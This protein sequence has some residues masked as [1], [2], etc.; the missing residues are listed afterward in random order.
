M[1]ECDASPC[2]ANAA[3]SNTE[4]GYNCVCNDNFSGDGFSC[5]LDDLCASDPCDANANCAYDAA[6]VTCT[7]QDGY[8]GSKIFNY[9]I[10]DPV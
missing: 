7:C 4:G 10:S 8:Q 6:G 1:N 2:D 3:C 5:S 9:L